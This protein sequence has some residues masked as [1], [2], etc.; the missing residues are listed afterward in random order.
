MIA[1]GVSILL[2]A[3]APIHAGP[4][5]FSE[6]VQSLGHLQELRLREVPQQTG[7]VAGGVKGSIQTSTVSGSPIGTDGPASLDTLLAG[8]EIGS[9]QKPGVEV[10][11]TGDVEGTICD[12]GEILIA[13]GAWPKWPLLFL[14]VIPLFFLPECDTCDDTPPISF[15]T[16][17]PPT[18]IVEVPEPMSLFLFGSGLVALGAGLRRRNSR[19]K[20]KMTES[21]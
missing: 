17:T 11:E 14:S 1:A 15:P 13:G 18:N 5:R 8:V 12:C 10:F 16:P 9:A 4:V 3:S 20:H 19:R 2:I 6:V 21:N 7:P